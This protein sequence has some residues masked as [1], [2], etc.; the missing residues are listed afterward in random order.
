MLDYSDSDFSI[1]LHPDQSGEMAK[2]IFTPEYR[3]FLVLLRETR[4]SAG[5]TQAELAVRLGQTQSLVSKFERGEIRV[6]V[7]QLRTICQ[8]VG[9]TLPAFINSLEKRLAK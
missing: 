5:V 4:E 9:T 8:I 1:R 6:D 7:I 3:R 2:S